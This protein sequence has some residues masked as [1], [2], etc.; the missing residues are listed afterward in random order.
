[1]AVFAIS[2]AAPG[3]IMNNKLDVLSSNKPM[4]NCTL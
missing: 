4:I 3:K 1:V 2:P